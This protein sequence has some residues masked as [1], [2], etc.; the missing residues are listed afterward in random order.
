MMKVLGYCLL[1][2]PFV[3]VVAML[4]YWLGWTEALMIAGFFG[5]IFGLMQLGAWLVTRERP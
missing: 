3:W 2:A 4:V 5:A 1:S